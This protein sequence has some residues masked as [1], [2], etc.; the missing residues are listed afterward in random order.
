LLVEIGEARAAE[1]RQ[2]AQQ[3]FSQVLDVARHP[4]GDIAH[5]ALLVVEG[6]HLSDLMQTRHPIPRIDVHPD[7]E[8]PERAHQDEGLRAIDRLRL[9]I[10]TVGRA[11]SSF[12]A[13][14]VASISRCVALI[15]N[16]RRSLPRPKA[17]Y[18]LGVRG[19]NVISASAGACFFPKVTCAFQRLPLHVTPITL[20]RLHG[21][22]GM[23]SSIRCQRPTHVHFLRE[24]AFVVAADIPLVATVGL[25]QFS[26]RRHDGCSS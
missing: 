22:L 10:L 26:L 24:V 21:L 13:P 14:T 12:E 17:P 18:P 2:E 11:K 9:E 8:I 25:D 15:S 23:S 4:G 19:L 16:A 5:M 20:P 3:L 1:Q 7:R 6:A